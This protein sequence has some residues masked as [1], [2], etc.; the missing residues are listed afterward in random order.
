MTVAVF[1]NVTTA[2]RRETLG[3]ELDRDGVGPMIPNDC[4]GNFRATP[5]RCGKGIDI[6][7]RFLT[8][9]SGPLA[10]DGSW[11]LIEFCIGH[12]HVP[13]PDVLVQGITVS[14]RC[15]GPSGV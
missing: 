14:C 1:A 15:P 7:L 13:R 8:G 5:D 3:I 9:D 6:G 11:E 10:F 12:T 4:R 2:G